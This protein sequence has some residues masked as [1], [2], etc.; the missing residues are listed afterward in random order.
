MW[1]FTG[2]TMTGSVS[3]QSISHNQTVS[4]V[5]SLSEGD[6]I[7]AMFKINQSASFSTDGVAAEA[8][9][10]LLGG[11]LLTAGCTSYKRSTTKLHRSQEESDRIE[12]RLSPSP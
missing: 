8:R 5:P 12:N 10:Q 4:A 6:I 2:T 3:R 7:P 11:L 1:T 9:Q